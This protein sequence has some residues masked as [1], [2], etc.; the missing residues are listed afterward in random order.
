MSSEILET[1]TYR[2]L[3]Q[4][5]TIGA[6][7]E[8]LLSSYPLTTTFSTPEWLL[9]WW[10]SFGANQ[11]LLAAAF[12]ADSRLVALALFSITTTRIAKTIPL[13][14]LRLMGDGSKDSDNLDLPV[15]PGFEDRFAASLL[16][17]LKSERSAW[18]FAELNT[19]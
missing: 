5:R 16:N 4:L 14:Q 15:M 18:D 6:Q 3:E 1:R 19:L 8:E 17:F 11:S 9:P 10:R 13:Q 2:S 7:W 12:F